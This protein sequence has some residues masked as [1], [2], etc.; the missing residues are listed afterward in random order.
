MGSV[1]LTLKKFL[2]ASRKPAVSQ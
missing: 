1:F 2:P